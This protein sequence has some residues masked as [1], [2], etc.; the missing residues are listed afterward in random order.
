MHLVPASHS[1]SPLAL[2][3]SKIPPHSR[4]EHMATVNQHLFLPRLEM[5]GELLGNG[6]EI[7]QN[8]ALKAPGRR[9]AWCG[10][11]WFCTQEF[12]PGLL[13]RDV[14]LP[15]GNSNPK[16]W[17]TWHNHE[18]WWYCIRSSVLTQPP[19]LV[20]QIVTKQRGFVWKPWVPH[21]LVVYQ[22]VPHWNCHIFGSNPPLPHVHDSQLAFI[23]RLFSIFSNIFHEINGPNYHVVGQLFHF[24]SI[25]FIFFYV[26]INKPL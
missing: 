13:H 3:S 16:S 4:G 18:S 26:F 12:F 21:C 24:V 8:H 22:R 6:R 20:Q 23:Y 10:R 5:L 7:I 11:E 25:Q 2:G 15:K 17:R 1:Q 14:K 9:A 19:N